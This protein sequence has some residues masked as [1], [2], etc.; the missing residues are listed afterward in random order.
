MNTSA[1]FTKSKRSS[2][3][4]K[5]DERFKKVLTD[6]RFRAAPGQVDKYGRK[7]KTG[8]AQAQRELSEFYEIEDGEGNEVE[9]EPEVLSSKAKGK[10][11]G[12]QNPRGNKGQAAGKGKSEEEMET[13]LDY[14]S[15]L[16]RGEVSDE[17]SDSESGGDDDDSEAS[18]SSSD[19]EDG[20]VDAEE[21]AKGPLDIPDDEVIEEDSVPSTRRLAIQNCDWENVKAKDLL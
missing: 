8:K 21:G 5:V 11:K 15:R 20:D 10:G 3:K 13:R 17:D 12:H 7:N 6:D 16:A 19:D 9:A 2:K 1:L 4:V 18:T 14:L